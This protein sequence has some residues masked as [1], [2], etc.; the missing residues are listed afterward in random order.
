MK[1]N[2]KAFTLIELLAVIVILAIIALIATPIVLSIID[3]S[4]KSASLRSA[5]YY[6]DGVE[7]SVANSTLENK[8]IEDGVYNIIENGNICLEYDTD[9]KCTNVLEVEVNGEV[10][11]IGSTVTIKEGTIKRVNLE[12]DGKEIGSNPDGS[13]S[14]RKVCMV[15]SGDGTKVGDEIECAGEY[16]YVIEN[17]GSNISM[18]SKYNLDVGNIYTLNLNTNEETKVEIENPTGI[19]K[20]EAR[21]AI[22]DFDKMEAYSYGGVAFSNSMYWSG[23]ELK[24]SYGTSY[25][26]W[27]YTDKDGNVDE[28]NNIYTNVENYEKYLKENGVE[29]AEGTL[30][31]YEQLVSLGCDESTNACASEVMGES[32]NGTAPEWVYYTSY[33][34]GAANV[35]NYVLCVYSYGRFVGNTYSNFG[36]FGVRPVVNIMASEI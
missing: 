5:E 1:L 2:N 15:V 22:I 4:K 20:K 16:F 29:S 26:A 36:V 31:S 19:Q 33:W 35:N 17:D 8:N 24:T 3:D 28:N 23:A 27:V 7:L 18:L 14:F 30:I 12:Y 10:P 6:L 13:L 9:N 21:G 32:T 25:P 34:S 11:D